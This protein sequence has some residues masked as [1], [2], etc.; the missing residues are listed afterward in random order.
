MIPAELK[1]IVRQLAEPTSYYMGA[2]ALPLD[3]PRNILLFSRAELSP[4]HERNNQH[5]RCMLIINLETRGDLCLDEQV[6][7]FPVGAA[8]LVFPH[9]LHHYLTIGVPVNWLFITFELDPTD[10][11]SGLRDR[12]VPVP[13]DGWG[14]VREI[15]TC[16]T[17]AAPAPGDLLRLRHALALLLLKLAGHRSRR[18]GRPVLGEHAV[19]VIE[20]VNQCVY[21]RLDEPLT[22]QDIA[23]AVGLSVSHLRAEFRRAMGVSLGRYVRRVRLNRA[24]ALLRSTDWPVSEV[25]EACGFTSLY[26]FSRTF[27]QMV[28]RSPRAFRWSD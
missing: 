6:L 16:G 3:T 23:A 28:G 11:L 7:P 18:R 15:L 9:Q 1:T 21:E 26:S 24:M 17:A 4:G 25:G 5:H 2:T 14:L 8:V 27:K 20:R 13:A 22:N 10:L 12:A 19:S